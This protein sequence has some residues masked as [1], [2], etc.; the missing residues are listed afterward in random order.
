MKGFASK[1]YRTLL[2]AHVDY[3]EQ[4]WNELAS[5]KN[6]FSSESDRESVEAGLTMVAILGL[7]DPL[8]PGIRDAVEKCHSSG[9]NV[10]MVTG[11][12]LETAIAIS[13]EAGIITQE[14]LRENED[15]YLCMT[16]ESFREIVG[17]IVSKV[18][19]NT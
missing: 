8:K 1:C 5:L 2:V 4:E 17:G 12:S 16:G 3:T 15:G 14:E 11:D 6:N 9:V 7:M 19:P 10:R 18:D 13:L